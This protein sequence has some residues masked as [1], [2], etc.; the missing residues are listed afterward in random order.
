MDVSVDDVTDWSVG[1]R[2]CELPDSGKNLIAHLCKTRV[3]EQY[4]VTGYLNGDIASGA[5]QHVNVALHV[6]HVHLGALL[7]Y[8][9]GRQR[10]RKH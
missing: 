4:T 1:N 9:G 5:H 7:C 6:K 3:D 10:G 8:S 2:F